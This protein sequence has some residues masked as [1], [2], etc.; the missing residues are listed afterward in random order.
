MG[1]R[2]AFSSVLEGRVTSTL[3]KGQIWVMPCVGRWEARTSAPVCTGCLK[4]DR[5]KHSQKANLM[6]KKAK[7]TEGRKEKDN[8]KTSRMA[9]HN[10]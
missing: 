9:K 6:N 2:G 5:S 8:R 10:S 3:I 4:Y 7:L 1:S